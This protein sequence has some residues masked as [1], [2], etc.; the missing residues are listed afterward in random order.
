MRVL[1]IFAEPFSDGG[2]ES[3]VMNMYNNI[4][5]NN[6]QFDFFTPYYCDNLKMKEKI[7]NLGGKVFIQGR[8]FDTKKRKK[9]FIEELQKFLQNN[10]YEIVHIHSGSV[11]A[12]A[13]GARIAKKNGVKN[14]IVHS[15]CTGINSLK[16]KVIKAIS[17]KIFLSNAT[18]YLACS[19]DAAAWKFPTK[20]MEENQYTVI[21]NGIELEKFSYNVDIRN[22]YRK[23]LN[24]GKEDFVIG[25][26]GR[27]ETQK[28]HNFLVEIFEEVSSRET[29]AKLLLVGTGSLK[30]EIINKIKEKNMKDK[31]IMLEN[32]ND[33]NKILQ[34]TDIFVFPSLFEG[35]GIV[36]IEAQ[37]A[38]LQTICSENIPEEADVTTLFHKLDIGMG[39]DKWAEKILEYKKYDRKNTIEEIRNKGYDAQKSAK[40]LEYIYNN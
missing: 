23:N 24:I 5:R 4:D 16:Y 7:E 32:R 3:F 25:H 15:H 28:N 31:V 37:A 33:V 12:L 17:E 40:A 8:A 19:K 1:Q 39:K 36:A 22:E 9:F 34:A 26:V 2:Q 13:Y 35:L 20:I 14:I 18:H 10:N 38:G 6:V 30:D 11:F 27:F 21:K 29:N